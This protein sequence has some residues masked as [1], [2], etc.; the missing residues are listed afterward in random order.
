MQTSSLSD[1]RPSLFKAIKTHS[2]KVNGI[3]YEWMDDMYYQKV[4]VK[5]QED[6]FGEDALLRSTT[7][8]ATIKTMDETVHFVT[9]SQHNFASSLAKIELKK[10]GKTVEFL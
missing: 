9:L 4:N 10:V 1:K 5:Y 7:R 8:N 2:F 3:V 6:C